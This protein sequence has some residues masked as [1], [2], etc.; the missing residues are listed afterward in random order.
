MAGMAV[1]VRTVLTEVV[2]FPDVVKVSEA[3]E[4]LETELVT[5]DVTM[6]VLVRV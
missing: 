3:L 2:E 5:M 4:P 1:H 6:L